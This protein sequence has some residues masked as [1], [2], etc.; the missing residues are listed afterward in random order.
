M[1]EI[2]SADRD[3]MVQERSTTE[4]VKAITDL[5]RSMRSALKMVMEKVAKI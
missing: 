3:L 4:V 5:Q 1:V 2:E